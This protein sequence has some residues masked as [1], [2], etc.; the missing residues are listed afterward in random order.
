MA[1]QTKN[2]RKPGKFK[3]SKENAMHCVGCIYSAKDSG[4]NVMGESVPV[5]MYIVKTEH[6]RPCPP[7][8]GCTVKKTEE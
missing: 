5:C 1:N 4:S 6:R 8:K 3:Y 7:G 2:V